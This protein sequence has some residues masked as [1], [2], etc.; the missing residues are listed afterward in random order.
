MNMLMY[1]KYD[2]QIFVHFLSKL[3][4]HKWIRI[5]KSPENNNVLALT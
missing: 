4:K 1:G 3:I 5:K 2:F